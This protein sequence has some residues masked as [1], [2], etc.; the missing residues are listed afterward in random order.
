MSADSREERRRYGRVKLDTP[1]VAR[2]GELRVRVHELSVTGFLISHE[3]RIPPGETHSFV[4][5]ADGDSIPLTCSVARSTLWRL[6]KAMGERSIYHSGLRIVEARREAFDRLRAVI[7]DRIIRALDEQKANARGIPPLA[8]YM[9]QPGKGELYRRCE[10]VDGVWRKSETIRPAQPPN[11]FTIS[12]DV[13]PYHVEMLCKTWET[14]TPEGR[15]LTQL[16]AELSISRAE[17]V[18]T[19]RYEP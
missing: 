4:L 6:A 15:R 16:L 14:T 11:G 9:Y 5:E 12:A 1:L 7:A 18:P 10:F 2:F 13:D 17:G 8:A 19:R 3:G